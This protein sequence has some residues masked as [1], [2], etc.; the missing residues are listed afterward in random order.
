MTKSILPD[1]NTLRI[2]SP[3]GRLSFPNVITA[4]E[5]KFNGKME[6][7]TMLFFPKENHPLWKEMWNQV[8]T[9]AVNELGA[10]AV[11]KDKDGKATPKFE[12]PGI[13]DGDNSEREEQHGQ[14]LLRAKAPEDRPPVLLTRDKKELT[15]D[16]HSLVYPGANARILFGLYFYSGDG[17]RAGVSLNLY[18]V[19]L[20]G[21]GDS[22]TGGG[23]M[24]AK[25]AVA[26]FDECPE[27]DDK[28]GEAKALDTGAD[29]NDDIPF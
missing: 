25:Q 5:N 26:M 11:G 10:K 29:F 23:S 22:L 8:L 28:S 19:Q 15:V 21:G 14:Y 17:F 18:A 1:V 9:Y 6:Y 27:L 24:S 7:S 13:I 3:P 4:R 16:D 2:V 12:H 20:L